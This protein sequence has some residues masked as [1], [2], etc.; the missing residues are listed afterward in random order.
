VTTDAS[1]HAELDGFLLPWDDVSTRGMF[2]ARGYFVGDRLSA[3]YYGGDVATKLPDTEREEILDRRIASPF[4]PVPG[5][6]FGGVKF[7]VDGPDG[8]ET[9]LPWRRK[10]FE[11]V[12][13]TP[14]KG[15]NR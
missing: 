4:T 14:P 5:R 8:V 3:A 10:T 11:Y 9:L 6:R 1:V 7:P 15:R 12:Q 2:G 13:A